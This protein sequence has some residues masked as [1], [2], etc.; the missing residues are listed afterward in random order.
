VF[1]LAVTASISVRGHKEAGSYLESDARLET[2]RWWV[3][4]QDHE[5][6]DDSESIAKIEENFDLNDF[7]DGCN[8]FSNEKNFATRDKV[9]ANCC[10]TRNT[11]SNEVQFGEYKHDME[12]L[13]YKG[14]GDRVNSFGVSTGIVRFACFNARSLVNKR[15]EFE[16]FVLEENLDIIGISET[17]FHSNILDSEVDLEGYT[18]FRKDRHD[19]NKRRGGGVAIYIRNEMN[20]VSVSEVN[21]CKFE[22]SLWCRINCNGQETLIGICYRPPNSSIS[23]DECLFSM[24]DGV[25]SGRVVIMGDFNFAALDWSSDEKTDVSHPF[26]ECLGRNFL[27]QHVQEPTRGKNYLDL[28]I[29][30]DD[31]VEDLR[32]GEPFE[33][34]D[35]QII[36]F[37]VNCFRKLN[38]NK[39][40][41]FNYHK[42]E[43]SQMQAK[44]DTMEWGNLEDSRHD[45][46]RDVYNQDKG[47]VELL[48]NR[49]KTNL[50]I[51]RDTFVKQ[52]KKTKIKSK[53]V[54]RESKKARVKKKKAWNNYVKSGKD[55]KL[56]EEYQVKLK[57]S[58]SE[59]TRAKLNYERRLAENIKKDSKSFYAYVNSK[60]TTSNK[61]GPLQDSQS[62]LVVDDKGVSNLLNEYFSSVFVEE[63]VNT[64]PE[65]R[66][67]YQ[68]SLDDRLS[69]INISAAVV[70]DRLNKINVNKS[71]GP[72]EIHGKLL[73]ELRSQLAEPLTV[74]FN[75]SLSTGNIPQDWRDADV[76]PLFKKG[77]RSKCENYRPVSL[78][79]IVCKLFE[80]IIKDE[81]TSHLDKFELIRPSQH[82]FTSGRSCLSNLLDFFETV[83]KELDESKDMDVIYLD[84]SKAFDKVP[85][86]RLVKKLRAHGITGEICRWIEN[87]L[88]DRRQRVMVGGECSQW[89]KVRSGVPQGSVLGPILFIIFI[90]DIDDGIMSKLNKFADD[91]KLGK[92]ISNADDVE[93]LRQDLGR[94]SKWASEWQMEFNVDKCSVLHMGRT[95]ALN[96]YEISSKQL[97]VSQTERDLGVLVDSNMKF[98]EQCN[99]AVNSA[100]AVLGMIKRTITCKNKNVITCLYKSLVRPKLEYCV[101]TWRPYLKKDIEKLEKI[102][103]RATK[104]IRECR[105]FNYSDR[106]KYTGLTTLEARRD[107]GDMIECFKFLRGYNKT[108]AETFF[109]LS[110][111]Q[112]TRGH[113]YKLEKKRSKLDI[114]KFFFS[115]R[116]VNEWNNLPAYVVEADSVN[117]F[118]NRYDEYRSNNT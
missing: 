49:I 14:G 45:R 34:S 61:I 13:S 106:L 83:T 93:V 29:S 79:S 43:Y 38:S 52:K 109:R 77:S 117:N 68:G 94:L 118:K 48:W 71:Q 113:G 91:C 31:I 80:S 89:V 85:H 105:Y 41:K 78:T 90:N 115:Q 66:C 62:H 9:S 76:V 107:R 114:R 67:K 19:V 97:K 2:N 59:N 5:S 25:S 50:F 116:V 64:I 84:F 46:R 53:W 99:S 73:Y 86:K 111:Q 96:T 104:M 82:G 15:N 39:T 35:H 110:G 100:N 98:I 1:K 27:H 101:Q 81:I 10:K 65:P 75:L 74:L 33:N 51:L 60:R 55:K 40:V 7:K 22:E 108:D 37:E 4:G 56:Y 58:K 47:N 87:W 36:R 17:W 95:N 44:A 3:L 6:L 30:S 11:W 42:V 70:L 8:S 23:N 57:Q 12:K 54:T 16:L 69:E 63:D 21:S 102:Q 28:V 32:V 18:L 26:V 112:R 24:I 72:D 103:R 20:P 88:R 92:S